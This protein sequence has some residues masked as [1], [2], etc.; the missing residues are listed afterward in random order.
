M[1]KFI[2]RHWSWLC[3]GGLLGLK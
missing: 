1:H 3:N 2:F